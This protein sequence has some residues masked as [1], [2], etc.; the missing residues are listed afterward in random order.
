MTSAVQTNTTAASSATTDNRTQA[1]LQVIQQVFAQDQQEV[2]L[3]LLEK[4]QPHLR[5]APLHQQV[6]PINQRLQRGTVRLEKLQKSMVELVKGWTAFVEGIVNHYK[7]CRASYEA[8]HTS[9]ALATHSA[10]HEV[11]AATKELQQVTRGVTMDPYIT[12][13]A[14]STPTDMEDDLAT[15]SSM[16]RTMDLLHERPP[17]PLLEQVSDSSY[18]LAKSRS[19]Y[20]ASPYGDNRAQTPVEQQLWSQLLQEE[21]AQLQAAFQPDGKDEP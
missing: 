13:Q 12:A 3:D 16:E 8:Q 14:T 20:R 15:V 5:Q 2:P 7:K 9:L 10:K 21:R 1:I 4:L 18:R 19:P 17:A 11:E 6:S